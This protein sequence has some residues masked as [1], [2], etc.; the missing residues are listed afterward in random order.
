MGERVTFELE[1]RRM[2]AK[3]PRPTS[4]RFPNK[5]TRFLT[6][7]TE[8]VEDHLI[9]NMLAGTGS[10]STRASTWDDRCQRRIS[11]SASLL[12]G[13]CRDTGP[14]PTAQSP[15]GFFQITRLQHE[16]LDLVRIAF[17]VFSIAIDQADIADHAALLQR[18]R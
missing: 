2:M 11:S 18:D 9:Q 1:E 15:S 7:I 16:T 8:G 14:G 4:C 10:I 13:R 3:C 5:A 12:P 6:T 17:D